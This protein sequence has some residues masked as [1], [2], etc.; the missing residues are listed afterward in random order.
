[1]LPIFL[2][3]KLLEKEIAIETKSNAIIKKKGRRKTMIFELFKKTQKVMQEKH[4]KKVVKK[5]QQILQY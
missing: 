2:R 1:M 4:N 3:Q 5:C